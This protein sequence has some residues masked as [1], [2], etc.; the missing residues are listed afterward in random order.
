MLFKL[1]KMCCGSR[2]VSDH[3]PTR[4][5]RP[6]LND[7]IRPL[8]EGSRSRVAC[9]DCFGSE[10]SGG[11]GGEEGLGEACLLII[12]AAVIA[13]GLF[14]TVSTTYKFLE[15]LTRCILTSIEDSVLEVRI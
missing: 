13:V 12:V 3:A 7:S 5:H 4:P 10:G 1:V 11:G 9:L 15:F 8:N 6:R 2:S 14:I